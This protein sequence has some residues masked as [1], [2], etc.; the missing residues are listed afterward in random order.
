M[1]RPQVL[2]ETISLQTADGFRLAA[3]VAVPAG[4][5]HTVVIVAP[6]MAV[7]RRFY[8]KWIQH[9]AGRGFGAIVIDY[10][11]MG[12]SAPRALRGFKAT[13]VDWARLDLQ[14]ALDELSRRWPGVRKVW[15]GHSIGG[16][17]LG[18]MAGERPV[19]K[20][21]IVASQSGHWRNWTGMRRIGIWALW[22]TMPLITL[23]AGRLPMKAVG[24]GLDVPS[25]VA[26]Q[27]A[28]WGRHPNYIGK[29]SATLPD[30]AFHLTEIEIRSVAIMDDAFAPLA[31]I[32]PLL[33]LYARAKTEVH[34]LIPEA[35]GM[36]RIGHFGAFRR[37]LLWREWVKFLQAA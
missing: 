5:P 37:P 33:L 21:L 1:T 2:I 16:Q 24:Q 10:R 23:L 34:R 4:E 14:A 11:G 19:E 27:W 31:S 28:E 6:A 17:L 32:G 35:E 22:H 25:G 30:A 9:L 15:F 18:L 26:R 20:A 7:P 3:D 13:L 36:A 29:T 12:D 8:R